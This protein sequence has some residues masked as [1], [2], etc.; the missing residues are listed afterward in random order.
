M[1]LAAAAPDATNPSPAPAR[2]R[3][4]VSLGGGGARAAYQVGVLRGIARRWPGLRFDIL[5]GESSGA[6]NAAFLAAHPGALGEA[7]EDLARLWGSLTSARVFRVDAPALLRNGLR[8]LLRLVSGGSRLAPG[9]RALLDTA[10]LRDLLASTLGGSGEIPG[11]GRNLDRGRLSAVAVTTIDYATG[12]TVSWVQ[13]RDVTGWVR[14]LRRSVP[15]LLSVEHVM[16]SAALPLLFPAV[17]LGGSWHGDGGLR[18]HAPLSPAIHL[19]ADRILAV[20]T[21][22]QAPATDTDLPETL[23][24]PPPAQVAG[25]LLRAVFLDLL[26]QDALALERVN[27]LLESVPREAWDGL[28]P[29]R[30][31]LLRPSQDLAQLAGR[32]EACLPRGVR[33]LTRGLGTHETASPDLLGLLMFEPLYLQ[34]LISLGEVD[35][36]RRLPDIRALLE[37]EPRGPAAEGDQ[38]P[39]SNVR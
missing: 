29:V 23:A 1:S 33:F 38:R 4:A 31:C 36:E 25:L 22:W 17:R 34:R 32:C 39:G 12:R 2:G 7:V 3:L 30:L 35:V 21:R 14:P 8:W 11:I 10:P 20:S 13:G 16:A 24:Y 5:M 19:G 27:R 28:R 9:V 37:Q 6:I 26:D 15:A 18:L